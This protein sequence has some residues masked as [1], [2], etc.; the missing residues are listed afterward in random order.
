MALTLLLLGAQ[1]PLHELLVIHFFPK[2]YFINLLLT[3]TSNE[4]EQ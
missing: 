1:K 3:V 2:G 4:E